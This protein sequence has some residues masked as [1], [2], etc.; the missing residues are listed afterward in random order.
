MELPEANP[1]Y[2]HVRLGNGR[3]SMV[4]LRHLAPT[5]KAHTSV[6]MIGNDTDN[7]QVERLI[8]DFPDVEIN[9]L[10]HESIVSGIDTVISIYLV[11]N[12]YM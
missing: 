9:N 10:S 7:V 2:D 12:M 4:S 5:N 1:Q 3:E 6:D 11:C 8:E